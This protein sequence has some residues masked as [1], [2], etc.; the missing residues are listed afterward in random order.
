MAFSMQ[1]TFSEEK[2][3]SLIAKF[4]T[5]IHL[6]AAPTHSIIGRAEFILWPFIKLKGM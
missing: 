3:F 2:D 4:I 6:T 5:F 1:P